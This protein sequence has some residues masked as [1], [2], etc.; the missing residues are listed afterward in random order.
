MG[1]LGIGLD[2]GREGRPGVSGCVLDCTKLAISQ[3]TVS[4][5][6]FGGMLVSRR[7]ILQHAIPVFEEMVVHEGCKVMFR[8]L[9]VDADDIKDSVGSLLLIVLVVRC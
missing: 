7:V 9:V 3:D 2:H 4:F 8:C 1:R 5:V 6:E